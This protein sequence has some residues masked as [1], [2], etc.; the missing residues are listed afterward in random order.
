[1]HASLRSAIFALG[2][3]IRYVAFGSGQRV[4]S[5][6]REDLRNASSNASDFYEEL[7]VNPTLLTLVRQRGELDCG[8]LRY[9]IVAYRNFN[10]IIMA[11]PEGH[12]S[13]CAALEA[14]PVGVATRVSELLTR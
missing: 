7:L 9:V 12:V 3:H 1:V 5:E 8:G 13:V 11:A 10:Q 14:D 2:P 6:Q 4:D